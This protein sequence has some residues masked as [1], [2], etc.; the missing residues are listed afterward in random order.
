MY[1]TQRHIDIL[2]MKHRGMTQREIAITL[3][4]SQPTVHGHLRQ[5][6]AINGFDRVEDIVRATKNARLVPRERKRQMHR[7]V[8]LTEAGTYRAQ[9]RV[10][11]E[12]R[13]QKTIS[14]GTYRTEKQAIAARLE[15]ETKYRGTNISQ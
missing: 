2:T 15:A 1:L 11:I 3:G 4:I 6:A 14:L 10:T 12:F 8:R 5:A 7:G 13:K 9:I